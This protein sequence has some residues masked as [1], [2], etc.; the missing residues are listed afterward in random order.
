[1]PS[2]KNRLC[3]AIHHG[4]RYRRATPA[5]ALCLPLLL[6]G[7]GGGGGGT[8]DNS[9]VDDA[10]RGG[11]AGVETD[12]AREA[13]GLARAAG[14]TGDPAG[15]RELPDIS[16][17]LAQLGMQL[18]FSAALSGDRDTACVSCHHPTLGGGDGLALS[19]GV[20]AEI[21]A[22]LGPGRRH[23]PAGEQHDGGPTV[24]RN[25]PTTFNIGL[26]DRV[27]FHDGR[28]ESLGAT[29]GVNGDDGSGIRTPDSPHGVADPQAGANLTVAQARFPV[30][31]HEEMR[32]FGPLAGLDNAALRT[33]LAQR[34]GD[35]GDPPGGY[36][37]SNRWL[38]EFRNALQDPD[39][40]AETL[41][42]FD[43]IS[44]AIATYQR[45]QVFVD[46]PWRAFMQGDDT[47]IPTAAQRGA[48]LFFRDVGDG[49]ASCVACHRGDLFSDEDFHVLAMP[50]I[51]RGKGDGV[52]GSEDYGRY[53]ETGDP[54]Q[55][56]AFRTP[57]LLN[58]SV[59]G[60]WGH[61]GAY[62]DLEAVVRHHLDPEL[63]VSRYDYGQLDAGVQAT[64]LL[65]NTRRALDQLA[66]L[67]GEGKS[68][69]QRVPLSD[70]EVADLLAF[71]HSLTDPCVEDRDCLAAWIPDGDDP[72]G[73]RIL[74]IDDAGRPL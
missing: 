28:V 64:Q 60:P 62:T 71:L 24:P 73:L 17:P 4:S 72:D 70:A 43:H 50:Q 22:L 47:A 19:I 23:S 12:L 34:L 32:N 58:V 15:G 27:L 5:L 7:C 13:R 16:E 33:A 52:D 30:T 29:P 39:G 65:P 68:L 25:A 38:G 48:L 3:P 14:M 1:M 67:Q 9:G 26:W 45:S 74:A 42:T 55:R 20:D 53:R 6:S 44:E 57:T 2:G 31:S 54:D 56:Y 49:G 10:Q 21:P 8:G 41:I 69:L 36:L 51:G 11:S 59:T 63:A 35:Y 18:F 46:S 66:R 37:V 61:A 40:S